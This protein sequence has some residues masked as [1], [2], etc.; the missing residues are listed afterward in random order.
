MH[1]SLLKKKVAEVSTNQQDFNNIDTLSLFET[2]GVP[3]AKRPTQLPKS[4]TF[5]TNHPVI[6]DSRHATVRLFVRL[7]H[8]TPCHQGVEYLRALTRPNFYVLKLPTK[9]G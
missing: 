4:A 6:L 3:C 8:E 7:L 9:L 2:N 1:P 5:G